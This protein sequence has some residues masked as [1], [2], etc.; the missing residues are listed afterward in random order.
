[1]SRLTALDAPR[2]EQ[3]FSLLSVVWQDRSRRPEA[4]QRKWRAIWPQGLR[5]HV[6]MAYCQPLHQNRH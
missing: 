4:D 6:I 5:E 1:M 3:L 2:R